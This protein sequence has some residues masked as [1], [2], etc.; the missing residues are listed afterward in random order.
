MLGWARRPPARAAG[1]SVR[2]A[3]GHLPARRQKHEAVKT[4]VTGAP[5][6]HHLPMRPRARTVAV[7]HM[8]S[9][10]SVPR[11]NAPT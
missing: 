10:S 8:R 7:R 2:A 6:H 5:A 11:P 3:A 9:S 4:L 1:V